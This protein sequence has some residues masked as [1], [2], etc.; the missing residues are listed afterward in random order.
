MKKST[1]TK[2]V[3]IPSLFIK[4][5]FIELLGKFKQIIMHKSPY[6]WVL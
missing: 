3:S 5:N 4:W 1:H 6:E 2:L